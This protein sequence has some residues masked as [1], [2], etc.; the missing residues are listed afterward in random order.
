MTTTSRSTSAPG[1]RRWRLA[2]TK[3]TR[4]ARRWARSPRS[5]CFGSVV[6]SWLSLVC[7]Q[8]SETATSVDRA[9]LK[10]CRRRFKYVHNCS[11]PRYLGL[12]PLPP[13]INK[14]NKERGAR[15]GM[16]RFREGSIVWA[17]GLLALTSTAPGA[18]CR[19]VVCCGFFLV[20]GPFADGVR[21][22]N[23]LSLSLSLS[24]PRTPPHLAAT[25]LDRQAW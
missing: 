20:C 12:Q 15:A 24:P 14:W 13:A 18:R 16:V 21:C 1:S 23:P 5:K 25:E 2:A 6:T 3:S 10:M 7:Q 11:D 19:C 8:Q 22:F 4:S 17:L 9:T